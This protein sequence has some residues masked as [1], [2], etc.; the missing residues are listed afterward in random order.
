MQISA[1]FRKETWEKAC[2]KLE[3]VHSAFLLYIQR[4]P[5]L[6]FYD[7]SLFH[8]K[9]LSLQIYFSQLYIYDQ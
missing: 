7:S 1:N 4:S 2:L 6:T 9:C 8:F 3:A 5:E